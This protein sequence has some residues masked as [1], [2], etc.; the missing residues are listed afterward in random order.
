MNC[1]D[2][3]CCLCRLS[4][5]ANAVVETSTAAIESKNLP[6]YDSAEKHFLADDEESQLSDHV[7]G[8]RDWPEWYVPYLDL[9]V[10]F[11]RV[12]SAP[13]DTVLVRRKHLKQNTAFLH[14]KIFLIALLNSF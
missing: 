4:E 14:G 8:Q 1:T 12:K 6:D 2:S 10:I 11:V 3:V 5:T 7:E 13:A 9:D